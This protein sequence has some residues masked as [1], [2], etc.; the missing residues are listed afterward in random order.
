M[1]DEKMVAEAAIIKFHTRCCVVLDLNQEF[2]KIKCKECI[3]KTHEGGKAAVLSI[4]DQ[5]RRSVLS[6]LLWEDTFYESGESIEKRISTLASQCDPETVAALA[7][8]ARGKY[9]LRSVPLV[10]AR[11]LAR[12]GGNLVS[13]TIE[14]IIQRPDEIAKFIELYWKDGKQPLAKQVKKG[15]AKAF[16]KFNEY[17][18]AKWKC[19]TRNVTLRDVMFLVHPKPENDEQTK[20]FA[21]LSENAL[22]TPDTWEVQLS[23]LKTPAEKAEMWTRLINENKLGALALL[24]NI[25][26]MREAGVDIETI[27]TALRNIKVERVLPYR[28]VTAAKHNKNFMTYLEGAMYRCLEG[29]ERIEGKT[30][31]L[32]DVSGSMEDIL[33]KASSTGWNNPKRLAEMT[34]RM[35]A[36][37]GLAILLKFLCKDI[38]IYT[39]SSDLVKIDNDY[40][41]FNL[42]DKIN[43]SQQHGGT[44]LGRA[45]RDVVKRESNF[46]RMIIITD[47]QAHDYI[48]TKLPENSKGYIMNVAAYE[49]GIDH[50]EQ[51]L[52]ITGFSES[53]IDFI[54]E[55]E[56]PLTTWDKT[57][58]ELFTIEWSS[59]K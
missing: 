22:D 42:G 27:K 18:L 2:P 4:P 25:R 32:V 51:W 24:K 58:D 46:D 7:I 55:A 29:K 41:G 56:K 23:K 9:K 28:F 36:A 19:D 43:K 8:E 16:G 15:L 12:K 47:E 21:K 35:D 3:M 6:C 53:V 45:V 34:T 31:L 52:R 44:W 26:G 5:L 20:M 59:V 40:T 54:V 30:V 14:H 10:L 1:T 33:G 39:F 49:H 17:Q 50:D 57:I 13:K 48:D 38:V 11:E 37:I